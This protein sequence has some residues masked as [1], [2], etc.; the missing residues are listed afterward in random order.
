MSSILEA[1]IRKD[2]RL[3]LSDRRSVITSFAVPVVLASFMGFLTSGHNKDEVS[4]ISVRIANQDG[5]PVSQSVVKGLSADANLDV[6][7]AEIDEARSLVR[8]GK[9]AV[10]I[11]LPKGFGEA[12]GQAFFGAER[13]PEVLLL[14]DPSHGAEASMLGG[15]LTQHV[16][17]AVSA[18][19]FGTQQGSTL[20]SNALAGLDTNSQLP[21]EDKTALRE[22][23]NGVAKWQDYKMNHDSDD[24]APSG[25]LSMPFTTRTEQLTSAEGIAYNGYA[26]SFGGMGVQFV[27]FA[28]IES[29]VGILTE[30]QRGLWKRLRAAP[31]SRS[32]LLLSR[33]ISGALIGLL[34][35]LV[36][37]GFGA[38]VFK[39]RIEGSVV[40]F[41]LICAAFSLMASTFGLLIASLGKT[42][43]AARGMSAFA[44]LVMVML[45]G[46][47]FPAF[48]FP[49]LLQK[50][51][52][53]VPTRW[54]MD[55]L[56]AMT[57]RGL[58]I[59]AALMPT[60]ML[61]GFATVLGLVATSRFRWDTE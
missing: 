32:T 54:A 14:S 49:A 37:F 33:A 7:P 20:V 58:G 42:P 39:I 34:V 50:V 12:T 16:M 11:V 47:W 52:L 40:G 18:A 24:A 53:F 38:T 36:L 13:K 61:L 6:Q 41:A 22:M 2:I 57:W 56:D 31:L 15:I 43:Q 46:A 25:G 55:G 4:R 21:S 48:L 29:A 27:L 60:A 35:L 9:V 30:R 1:L 5:S 8:E 44:V 26:H 3:F 59:D 28:A 10:A 51:T 23:L 45:G 17:Q 19:A